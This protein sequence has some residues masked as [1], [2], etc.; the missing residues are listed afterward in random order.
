MR[1]KAQWVRPEFTTDEQ[2]AYDLVI[3][4]MAEYEKLMQAHAPKGCKVIFSYRDRDNPVVAIVKGAKPST[5]WAEYLRA[6]N[7]R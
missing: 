6:N 7:G 2:A 5:S 3:E 4:A 1:D